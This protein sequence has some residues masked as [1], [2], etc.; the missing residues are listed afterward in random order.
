MTDIVPNTPSKIT[1]A[2]TNKL[3]PLPG[4]AWLIIVL[5]I[6]Y[7]IYYYRKHAGTF[8]ATS[9]PGTTT[10]VP[11]VLGYPDN[12]STGTGI[13]EGT[14]GAPAIATNSQ[15]AR[16]AVNQLVAQGKYSAT[17]ASNA[18]SNYL[19]GVALSDQQTAIINDALTSFST[20]P[21]G[22]L[23]TVTAPATPVTPVTPAA[24]TNPHT[25]LDYIRRSDGEIAA[26]YSD[27]SILPLTLSEYQSRGAPGYTQLADS[28][29]N[30][31]ARPETFSYSIGHSYTVK[32][33]DTPASIAKRFYGTETAAYLVP[34]AVA[35]GQ[36]INLV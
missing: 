11:A 24:P 19:N 16:N 35:P 6:A 4:Y 29:Y 17:D 13:I 20:P 25:L 12:S 26:R 2:F 33:G 23:P 15:W 22:V 8:P 21:E 10:G 7:A 30:N 9:T 1:G 18:I 32:A 31:Y 27:N 36:V 14:N 34:T 28:T 3:G 5:G